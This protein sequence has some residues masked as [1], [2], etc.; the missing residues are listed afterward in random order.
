MLISKI[1]SHT[2]IRHYFDVDILMCSYL[3]QQQYKKLN[4]KKFCTV[5][6][7]RWTRAE[8]LIV[9]DDLNNTGDF[10]KIN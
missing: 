1:D 9:K 5:N 2:K 10:I 4:L 6:T 3:V 7:G 8:R